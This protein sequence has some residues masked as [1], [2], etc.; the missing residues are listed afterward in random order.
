MQVCTACVLHQVLSNFWELENPQQLYVDNKIF[1]HSLIHSVAASAAKSM[2]GTGVAGEKSIRC[3]GNIGGQRHQMSSVWCVLGLS[4]EEM[5]LMCVMCCVC[6]G[7]CA[8]LGKCTVW[9]S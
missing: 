7:K 6:L 5:K 1:I 4:V 8:C 2:C 9:G 3:T